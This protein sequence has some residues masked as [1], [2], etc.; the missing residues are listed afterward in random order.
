MYPRHGVISTHVSGS[1]PFIG[2]TQALELIGEI[3]A[4]KLEQLKLNT[5][6]T[7]LRMIGMEAEVSHEARV[8]EYRRT[9]SRSE[10]LKALMAKDS[11]FGE[12]SEAQRCMLVQDVDLGDEAGKRYLKALPLKRAMRRRLL[13]TRWIVNLCSGGNL[14]GLGRRYGHPLGRGSEEESSFQLE[15]TQCDVPGLVMGCHE[16]TGRGRLRSTTSWRRTWRVVFEAFVSMVGR[17]GDS[18]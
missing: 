3:E 2:E 18:R 16:G 8:A 1:C 12:L 13:T 7:Q 6:Q 4:R 9:G 11:V 5:V 14:Q 17:Q 15:R 10:G